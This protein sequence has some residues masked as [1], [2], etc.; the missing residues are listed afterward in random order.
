[1]K[2]ETVTERQFASIVGYSYGFIKTLR[3]KGLISHV[4]VGRSIRYRYPEHVEQF[5]KT[6]EQQSAQS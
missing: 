3:Q 1:M 2:T 4:R 5:L 6:R